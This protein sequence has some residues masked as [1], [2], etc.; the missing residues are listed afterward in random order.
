MI[1]RLAERFS[2]S[3]AQDGWLHY[4]YQTKTVKDP[5]SLWL[6]L[7]KGRGIDKLKGR[8]EDRCFASRINIFSFSLK[9]VLHLTKGRFCNIFTGKINLPSSVIIT[10]LVI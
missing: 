3:A 1:N 9:C 8:R 2:Q 5:L 10:F 7:M 4:A 6:E